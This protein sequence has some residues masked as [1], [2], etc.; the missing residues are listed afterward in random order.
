MTLNRI[1]ELCERAGVP[2]L[3]RTEW[4]HSLPLGPP[5]V[6]PA[7]ES[8]VH[9]SVTI[10]DDDH[11]LLATG[12][13]IADMR[14]I[15][16]IGRQ[17]FGRFPYSWCIHPSGVVGEGAG[18]NIGAHTADHNSRSFGICAIGNY[19]A[20][21]P[22]APMTRAFAVLLV[23][24]EQAGALV[25]GTHPTGGHRDTKDTECP[26]NLL[27]PQLGE[28]RLLADDPTLLTPKEDEMPK[29]TY[30]RRRDRGEVFLAGL[31]IPPRHVTSFDATEWLAAREGL[32]ITDAREPDPAGAEAITDG[33]GSTRF[34]LVVDDG[35]L[36]GI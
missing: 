10:A 4:G 18:F 13:V 30:V 1:A 11:D 2:Y 32:T 26:G 34:V 27:Y 20:T 36:F 12:D 17:R 29:A 31:T 21:A 9:H 25:P 24:L 22:P 35:T 23:A 7:A 14:E 15:E 5:M 8:W 16:R 28:I 19:S 6:L 33:N 3:S